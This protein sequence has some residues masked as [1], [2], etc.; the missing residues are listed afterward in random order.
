MRSLLRF[1]L[2]LFAHPSF[3][4]INFNL[5]LGFEPRADAP[6]PVTRKEDLVP[7]VHYAPLE[8]QNESKEFV[9]S[10]EFLGD[11]FT[12]ERDQLSLFVRTLYD[13]V[14]GGKNEDS[15]EES[16]DNSVQILE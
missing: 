15:D 6:K 4:G 12:F 13:Y 9:N 1:V 10:L 11:K 8:L 16:S 5:R 3:A 7:S 14:G 2:I